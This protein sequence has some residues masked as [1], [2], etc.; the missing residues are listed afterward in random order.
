MKDQALEGRVAISDPV[1]HS[2]FELPEIAGVL[3]QAVEQ[4]P[5]E[6]ARRALVELGGRTFHLEAQALGA[7]V[8]GR[9]GEGRD[10]VLDDE[11]IVGADVVGR[12]GVGH[13]L[14]PTGIRSRLED[15]SE[16]QRSV[17]YRAAIDWT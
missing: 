17:T 2:R 10:D 6:R 8:R 16:P 15:R 3:A 9:A 14:L 5:T 11:V 4:S 13:G 7:V 1:A 12:S